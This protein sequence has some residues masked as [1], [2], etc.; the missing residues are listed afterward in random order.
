MEMV[1][2]MNGIKR[3]LFCSVTALAL[4]LSANAMACE[5]KLKSVKIHGA[6]KINEGTCQQYWLVA[7]YSKG[8]CRIN[9]TDEADYW[10]DNS[11]WAEFTEEP[12]QLCVT[13]VSKRRFVRIRACYTD[14]GKTRCKNKR[15]KI[16]NNRR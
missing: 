6:K 13:E 16:R 11:P 2:T 9:V 14:D 3:C 1:A 10:Y 7:R 5:G 8:R 4:T 12:G 15:V